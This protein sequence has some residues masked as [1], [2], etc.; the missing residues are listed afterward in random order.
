M[1]RTRLGPEHAACPKEAADQ[2]GGL[3]CIWSARGMLT[4]GAV[5]LRRPRA[6]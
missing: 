5:A 3:C 4:P 1:K 6:E 2:P